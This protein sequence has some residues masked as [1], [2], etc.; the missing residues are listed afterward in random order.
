MTLSLSMRPEA[1]QVWTFIGFVCVHFG[2]AYLS[3]CAKCV[4][5]WCIVNANRSTF[6]SIYF[7]FHVSFFFRWFG[8]MSPSFWANSLLH[9]VQCG[10]ET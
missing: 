10:N 4:S 3:V 6:I 5:I 2:Y 9:I 1:S 8:G 7:F